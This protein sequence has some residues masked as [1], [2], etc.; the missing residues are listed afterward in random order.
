V[1]EVEPAHRVGLASVREVAA[2]RPHRAVNHML[3]AA[4]FTSS[5]SPLPFLPAKI[6]AD[7]TSAGRNFCTVRDSTSVNLFPP[8]TTTTRKIN[9]GRPR[10]GRDLPDSLQNDEVLSWLMAEI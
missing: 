7:S 10:N 9:R 1:T 6:N 4:W 3:P 5:Q 8:T 2:I